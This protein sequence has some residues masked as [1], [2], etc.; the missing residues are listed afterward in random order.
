MIAL[1]PVIVNISHGQLLS[2]I[3]NSAQIENSPGICPVPGL[4]PEV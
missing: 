3:M 4:S 1:V 2:G